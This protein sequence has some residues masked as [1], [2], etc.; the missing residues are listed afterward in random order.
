MHTLHLVF[1]E[2]TF[3]LFFLISKTSFLLRLVSTVVTFH[4]YAWLGNCPSVSQSAQSIRS[5][6]QLLA[7]KQIRWQRRDEQWWW[8]EK[9][10]TVLQCLFLKINLYSWNVEIYPSVGKRMIL[11]SETNC[12]S[13]LNH[14]VKFQFFGWLT[15]NQVEED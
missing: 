14:M 7:F 12:L 5:V 1:S 8:N 4:L 3:L 15:P 6:I 13:I 10:R 2:D 9:N 11:P